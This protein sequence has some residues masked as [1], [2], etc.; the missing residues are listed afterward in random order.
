MHRN[1][2][3]TRTDHIYFR[4]R[5]IFIEPLFLEAEQNLELEPVWLK[6]SHTQRLTPQTRIELIIALQKS[7]T[8]VPNPLVAGPVKMHA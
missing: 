2:L 6:V 4:T 1:K 7:V 3:F 5:Y 8:I